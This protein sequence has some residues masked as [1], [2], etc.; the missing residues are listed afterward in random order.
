M[1]LWDENAPPPSGQ[2]DRP[3]LDGEAYDYDSNLQDIDDFDKEN[4]WSP[5]PTLIQVTT[6]VKVSPV[7]SIRFNNLC[8]NHFIV[9]DFSYGT[10]S[11]TVQFADQTVEAP[12]PF[13]NRKQ[14]KEEVCKLA[15]PIME[16]LDE[17]L[18]SKK[19]KAAAA[20][21]PRVSTTELNSENFIGLL[22]GK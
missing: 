22:Q 9:P 8:V 19:R 11:A 1:Q 13:A 20:P 7:C 2:V 18:R 15:L 4:P 6:K 21:V 3:P 5:K 16:R 17:Q 10:A 12:G 14:A